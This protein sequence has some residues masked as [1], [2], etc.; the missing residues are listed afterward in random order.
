MR[1]RAAGFAAAV[2]VAL[3][4]P[5]AAQAAGADLAIS[6]AKSGRFPARSFVLTLP[7]RKA[8]TVGEV[9]ITENGGD[10]S[11]LHVT[12]GGAA[13]P[14]SFAT[15]LAID[16][17]QSMR[18][19]AI[20][21]AMAAARAF[22]ARR[23]ADQQLGVVFFSHA[24][25]IALAP[26]S[27]PTKID[28][29]L[30][31][32]PALS[33]GTR[34][35]D[36]TSS[37]LQLLAR[38]GVAVGSVIVLSDGAD[39]GSQVSERA[40]TS[41]ASRTHLRV[42]TVGLRSPSFTASS[43][44]TL[45]AGAGGA[46][47]EA[48]SSK[49]LGGIFDALG[50]RFG[51]E[52]LVTYRSTAPLG[53]KVTVNATVAGVR[54]AATTTYTTPPF[55]GIADAPAA[56]TT[57]GWASTTAALIV[58]LIAAALLGTGAFLLLR[59]RRRTLS[60]RISGFVI[61]DSWNHELE[62]GHHTPAMLLSAERSLAHS[63]LWSAFAED[64]EIS[65]TEAPPVRIALATLTATLCVLALGVGLGNVGLS[66]IAFFVPVAVWFA[67]HVRAERQRRAFD[68]QLAD[69]LQVIAS[70]MRAGHSF[71]G[72]MSVA[73]DD[74]QE[75]AKSEFRRIVSDDQLGI[76]LDA[77]ISTV[78]DR[79]HSPEL[80]YVGLVATLQRETGGNTAEV[81]DRV[82]ETIRERADL[83]RLVRTLTAQGRF[84]GG[85]VSVLPVALI[86]FILVSRPHYFDEVLHHPI[87]RVM[88]V[89]SVM[90][91]VFGWTAIRKIVDIKV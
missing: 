5:A 1:C 17:S 27:D 29:V 41:A 4:V 72:A 47:A 60:D 63:R 64:V 58:C 49:Q 66:V 19:Q 12:P 39:V 50:R 70:A 48:A 61:D 8:L 68:S 14:R 28:S 71:V 20:D 86:A 32:A 38:S 54:G 13:G 18:G 87:G 33:R 69:N 11:D 82:T 74:A 7:E 75:P 56:T 83:R 43:L 59:P 44:R 57:H 26:T 77:A 30:A 46:Y 79:M 53:S 31:R 85:V 84:G 22:A 9:A 76:P 36:A 52:Y 15:V 34:I 10:V 62:H 40:V 90:M 24:P 89:A 6:Q 3:L 23:N 2:I 55:S 67:V 21:D 65:G 25:T 73:A 81:I 51:N 91:I 35:F 16:A 80:E 88:I 37:A 78:A 42:F 45:A